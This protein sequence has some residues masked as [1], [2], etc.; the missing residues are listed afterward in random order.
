MSHIGSLKVRQLKK[1]NYGLETV[2]CDKALNSECRVFNVAG[3]RTHDDPASA[4][5]WE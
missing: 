5:G 1:S 4:V 2:D 3:P